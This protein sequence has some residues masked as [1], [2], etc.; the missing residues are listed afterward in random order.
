MVNRV[1]PVHLTWMFL[2]WSWKIHTD[3]GRACKHQGRSLDPESYPQPSFSGA[4][5]LN[6]IEINLTLKAFSAA[7]TRVTHHIAPR[8]LLL[9]PTRQH[10]QPYQRVVFIAA[11]N[12]QI[13]GMGHL[14]TFSLLCANIPLVAFP[15][16]IDV[17]CFVFQRFWQAFELFGT[18]SPP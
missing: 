9:Q 10:G 4:A 18:T 17:F 6:L 3:T 16:L 8:W 5:A 7:Q 12:Q 2:D 14:R 13:C 15:V 11:I 1:F